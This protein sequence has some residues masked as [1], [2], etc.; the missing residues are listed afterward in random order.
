MLIEVL[1]HSSQ[2]VSVV[3]ILLRARAMLIEV[4]AHSSQFVRYC[5][6]TGCECIDPQQRW[7]IFIFPS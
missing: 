7:T 2:D 3:L 6:L 4:L 5:S 1:A